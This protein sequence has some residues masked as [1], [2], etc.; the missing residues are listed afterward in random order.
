M[1]TRLVHAVADACIVLIALGVAVGV[2][3]GPL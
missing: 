1:S 2:L 3:W